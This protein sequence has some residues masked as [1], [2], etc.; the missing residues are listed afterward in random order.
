MASQTILGKGTGLFSNPSET[1]GPT[2]AW[3]L[4]GS[5]RVGPSTSLW[6]THVG[7]VLLSRGAHQPQTWLS[8][9][10]RNGCKFLNV[11]N[12]CFYLSLAW[13]SGPQ[14]SIPNGTGLEHS[15]E[16]G[17]KQTKTALLAVGFCPLCLFWEVLWTSV[18]L[19]RLGAWEWWI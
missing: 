12:R 15:S 4:Y 5:Q 7:C 8:Q 19:K 13:T 1:P 16:E 9:C 14:K 2:W 18:L 17:C 6:H 11:Y 3:L 10:C